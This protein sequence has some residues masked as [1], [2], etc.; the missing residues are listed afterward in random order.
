LDYGI[1]SVHVTVDVTKN[2][3]SHQRQMYELADAVKD[4]AV[5]KPYFYN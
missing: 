5:I 2:L 3:S 1:N 4:S